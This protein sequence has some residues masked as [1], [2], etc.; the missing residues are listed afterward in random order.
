[1]YYTG[2]ALVIQVVDQGQHRI[3]Y[4]PIENNAISSV[5]S[6]EI[7]G[8]LIAGEGNVLWVQYGQLISAINVVSNGFLPVTGININ[9]PI[10][11]TQSHGQDLF[12]LTESG[13]LRYGLSL[14]NIPTIEQQSFTL[15]EN[16]DGF[17][18]NNQSL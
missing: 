12:V 11:S 2:T 7:S 5:Q 15:L 14:S 9:E 18:V 8:N 6:T 4:Y 17:I 1:M 13:I 3:D 10:I 16:Q